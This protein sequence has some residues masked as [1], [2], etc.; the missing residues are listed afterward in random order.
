MANQ[1]DVGYIKLISLVQPTTEERNDVNYVPKLQINQEA[2]AILSDQFESP[3]SV[4]V[5]VGREGVGK[6]KLASLTATTLQKKKYGKTLTAFQSSDNVKNVT[7]GIWMWR[8]PLKDFNNNKGSI[9]LLDCEGIS[10][11]DETRSSHLYLF[12][13][14]ISTTFAVILRPP[15]I[16]HGQCNRLHDALRRF[17]QMQTPSVLPSVWLV[18]SGLAVL[19]NDNK[20]ITQD[21]WIEQVFT[22]DEGNNTLGANQVRELKYRYNY[23]RA[24]LPKIDVVN[25]VR[26]PELLEDDSQKVDDLFT[27][28]RDLSCEKYYTSLSDAIVQFLRSGGKRIPGSSSCFTFIRPAELAQFMSDLI[29]VISGTIDPNPD[30]LIGR[31]LL[32]RFNDHIVKKM[33]AKFKQ[34]LLLHADLYAKENLKKKETENEREQT[35]TEL[36]E[37][38]DH[39]TQDYLNEMRQSAEKQIY[40]HN[41][42]LLSCDLFQMRLREIQGEMNNYKE[43]DLLIQGIR[44]IH[45]QNI[46]STQST[47]ENMLEGT[48][49]KLDRFVESIQQEDLIEQSLQGKELQVDLKKCPKCSRPAGPTNLIHAKEDCNNTLG[50]HGNYYR[51]HYKPNHMVC[52][53]C[54][55]LTQI[56][57]ATV[58]CTVCGTI[59]DII[60]LV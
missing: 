36:Q 32:T 22:L 42:V 59:R 28:L 6:S 34:E 21:E 27:S 2:M 44:N 26:L 25:I 39:L 16:D 50:R 5:Y 10:H 12:S 53:A 19:K 58:R 9:L 60:G 52:D 14:I 8:W 37:A 20:I 33:I 46:E 41:S 18:P 31:Y 11:F 45:D 17:E 48:K 15:R 47:R 35:N 38:R 24:K 23:I 43:P 1:E 57:T 51:Y 56:P 7:D 29:D 40:G 13:M 3:I 30:Q 49:K 55:K 4:I 54:R